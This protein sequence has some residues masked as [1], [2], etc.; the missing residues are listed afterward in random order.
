MSFDV[1]GDYMQAQFRAP[2]EMVDDH[3]PRP[4][5]PNLKEST[6]LIGSFQGPKKWIYTPLLEWYLAH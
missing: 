6:R 3:D 1:I 4:R 5:Y 2:E